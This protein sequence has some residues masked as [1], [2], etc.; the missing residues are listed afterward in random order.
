MDESSGWA[1]LHP[2]L[3][4]EIAKLMYSYDDYIHLRC[5]CKQW[6]SSIPRIP[7]HGNPWMVLPFDHTFDTHCLEARQICHV[8]VPDIKHSFIRGSSHGYVITVTISDGT[9]R[10][11]DPFIK[12][13]FHLPP[14]STFPNIVSYDPTE[15]KYT[16]A[17]HIFDGGQHYLERRDKLHTRIIDKIIISSPPSDKDFMA[18]CIYGPDYGLAYCR[19][20]DSEWKDMP[21]NE[22]SRCYFQD[23]IFHGGK[24]YATNDKGELHE[25]D[26]K[27][28]LPFRGF[29]TLV[30]PPDV[31]SHELTRKYLVASPEGG[32]LM[33]I[34]NQILFRH[35]EV[36]I[37]C[38]N[39]T[40]K[41]DVYMLND[42]ERNQQPTWASINT[43]KNYA[44]VLGYNSSAW[45][46]PNSRF[47]CGKSNMIY[48]TDYQEI[49][50]TFVI[51]DDNRFHHDI[52]YLYG[53]HDNGLVDLDNG[54]IDRLFPN[55]PSAPPVW[56]LNSHH[57]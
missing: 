47:S 1:N 53:G 18:V 3:L 5:I 32:L 54:L 38:D 52:V 56:L 4:R 23:V 16:I 10:M 15:D 57:S 13:Q 40:Y 24:I 51:G 34:T 19:L 25:Y 43:L 17:E 35:H 12:S 46:L 50:Q 49:G 48:Y 11:I 36:E 55:L 28:G 29:K 31:P 9:L 8:R 41:F 2:E 7:D 44:L 30:T 26:A 14:I 22:I 27:T 33:V 21:H 42:N 20:G 45:M 6:N 37:K 39:W